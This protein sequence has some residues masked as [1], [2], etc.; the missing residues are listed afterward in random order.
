MTNMNP[1]L[2][3]FNYPFPTQG[4][5]V[6]Y[7]VFQ[8]PQQQSTGA[9]PLYTF[10]STPSQQNVHLMAP[11]NDDHIPAIDVAASTNS[12]GSTDV[13]M[14]S[15][16]PGKQHAPSTDSTGSTDV[17][18]KSQ[19]TGKQHAPLTT[20]IT[21]A[22]LSFI[23]S[24]MNRKNEFHII[25][26]TTQNFSYE[27]LK[28][29]RKVLFVSSDQP[30]KYMYR[31]L[32]DPASNKEKAAHC[33][34]SMIIKLKELES[35]SSTLQIACLAEDLYRLSQIRN[36]TISNVE[37]RLA[38]LETDMKEM[39]AFK[40]QSA[41]Q[42][43]TSN[44][45]Q[46]APL[47]NE[48]LHSK[49]QAPSGNINRYS[50]LKEVTSNER[51][52]SSSINKR[53]RS[54]DELPWNKI[55]RKRPKTQSFWNHTA[56]AA[57][58]TELLGCDFPEV[59]LMGYNY[60]A[61]PEVVKKHFMSHKIK[62]IRVTLRT[63]PENPTKSFVM[64]IENKDDFEKITQVLPYK[65]GARWY[66][67]GNFDFQTRPRAYYNKTACSP[68]FLLDS[69][70]IATESD[71]P[72]NSAYKTP[73]RFSVFSPASTPT[74]RPATRNTP[75]SSVAN[76]CT[77]P[78]RTQSNI[79][80]ATTVTRTVTSMI[81]PLTSTHTDSLPNPSVPVSVPTTTCTDSLPVFQVG[82]PLSHI[83]DEMLSSSSL[84]ATTT[85]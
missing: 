77:V 63:R 8:Y 6:P 42:M 13:P 53:N 73:S 14:R 47:Y 78:S 25:E 75:S 24:E 41:Q 29:A 38:E 64:K 74:L 59:F 31:Q 72:S 43:S 54:T 20:V 58:C 4:F 70:H 23:K 2:S 56:S 65:T 82:A 81:T 66:E 49:N 68:A 16:D 26:T 37:L 22:C 35:S 55:D 10:Q 19:D 71:S 15:Q 48:A 79:N 3:G 84:T 1:A 57:P 5:T 32:P 50:L 30:K 80:A 39:K 76:S 21:N 9:P 62:V 28:E 83:G 40:N 7:S 11:N 44:H 61:T 67:S 69:H 27:E 17:P 36:S 45:I 52:R 60:K 46:S 85:P 18:M 51:Q 34:N 33:T 12:T